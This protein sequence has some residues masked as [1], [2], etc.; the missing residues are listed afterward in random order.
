V[1]ANAAELER[2]NQAYD[3]EEDDFEGPDALQR[4]VVVVTDEDIQRELEEIRELEQKKRTLE[5]RVT[6][7]ERDLGGL[8]R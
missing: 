1:A 5:A 6:G 8:M 2:M 3:H 7:M 4:E